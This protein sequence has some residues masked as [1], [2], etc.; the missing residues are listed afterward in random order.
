MH[1]LASRAKR[2]RANPKMVLPRFAL[3]LLAIAALTLP[4][5]AQENAVDPRPRLLLD[6]EIGSAASLGFKL[7]ATAFGPAIEVPFASH[8]EL[9]SAALYSPDRKLITNDGNALNLSATALGFVTSRIGIVGK[10]EHA[11]LWTSQF[12]ENSWAPSAG[13]VIRHN[14]LGPGR[15]YVSYIFPTGCVWAA[16]SN[17]CAL[18]S[19]RL[20]GVDLRQDARFGSHQRWGFDFGL[21]HFCDQANP[22]DPQTGRRCH[23]GGSAM[24][25]F[26][27]E[28]HLGKPSL[29]S[30]KGNDPSDF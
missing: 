27:F 25:T 5:R 1:A 8:F 20:Q 17:P 4:G 24:V 7:P 18:Q 28:F 30:W 14:Y 16:S 15:L 10:L 26:S 9:Q 21:Y 2:Q 6:S 13:V 11:S 29:S 3:A 23:I 19:K 12:E 22:N